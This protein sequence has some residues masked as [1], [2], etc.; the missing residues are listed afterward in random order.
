MGGDV[1][2]SINGTP[3]DGIDDLIAYLVGKTRPDQ[4]VTM[5]VIRGDGERLTIPVTLGKRPGSF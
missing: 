2:V 1:I 3:I 4:E 5:E